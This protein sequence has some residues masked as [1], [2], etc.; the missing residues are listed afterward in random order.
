MT[1]ADEVA[2][3]EATIASLT[4]RP[5]YR[6]STTRNGRGHILEIVVEDTPNA[7]AP[8]G[9]KRDQYPETLL[10][11]ADDLASPEA[12]IRRIVYGLVQGDLHEHIEFLRVDGAQ[13]WNPHRDHCAATVA[14]PPYWRA[15]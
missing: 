1:T 5:G 11:T 14:L 6:V 3:I 15:A 12:L 2:F 4:L 7:Y 8:D 10:L 13:P 9:P